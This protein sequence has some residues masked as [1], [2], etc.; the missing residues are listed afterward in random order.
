VNKGTD[1]TDSGAGPKKLGQA[2]DEARQE[3]EARTNLSKEERAQ[4]LGALGE[5][6][7][8]AMRPT[9]AQQ[10]EGAALL[11]QR[12]PDRTY[13]PEQVAAIAAS[14]LCGDHTDD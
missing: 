3:I 2:F 6:H 7:R 4:M 9:K 11:K 13:P 10:L 5:A 8:E 14:L 12:I 1:T